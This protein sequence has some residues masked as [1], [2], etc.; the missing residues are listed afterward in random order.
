MT[1]SRFN[2]ISILWGYVIYPSWTMVIYSNVMGV[3][4][5]SWKKTPDDSWWRHRMETFSTL[6]AIC[7]GNSPASGKAF[8]LCYHASVNDT[9]YAIRVSYVN[10]TSFNDIWI[11]YHTFWKWF[12]KFR[13]SWAVIYVQAQWFVAMNDGLL[14]Y[15]NLFAL[16]R[17]IKVDTQ[18]WFYLANG[19][20][21]PI[22]LKI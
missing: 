20:A 5:N 16:V 11:K 14:S 1:Y 19:N 17:P 18:L 4:E 13:F 21:K 10:W 12:S 2:I 22:N 9:L 3:R 8:S 7:A 6:L 15:R